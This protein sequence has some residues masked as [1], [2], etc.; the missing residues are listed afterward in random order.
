MITGTSW[1]FNPCQI[2]LL[3]FDVS[4]FSQHDLSQVPLQINSTRYPPLFKD[5]LL[6]H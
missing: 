4:H 3:F 2:W 1:E 5:P 6:S